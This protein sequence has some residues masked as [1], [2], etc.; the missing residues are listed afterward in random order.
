MSK[1][2]PRAPA[3]PDPMAVAN[4]QTQSNLSTANAE[5]TLNRTNQVTP[6]G[7]LTYSRGEVGPDGTPQWTANIELSPD[8]QKLLANDNEVSKYLSDLSLKQMRQVDNTIGKPLDMSSL[9]WMQTAVD[10]SPLATNVDPNTQA[11]RSNVNAGN[12]RDSIPDS[13]GVM[14]NAGYAGGVTGNVSQRNNLSTGVRASNEYQRNVGDVGD[15]SRGAT[16]NQPLQFGAESGPINNTIKGAGDPLRNNFQAGNM[17]RG[18]DSQYDRLRYD[19]NGKP[20][21]DRLSVPADQ[22]SNAMTESQKAAYNLQSQ[23]LDA[24]YGER[25]RAL[26]NRLI[27]QGVVQGSEAWDRAM[28]G[29]GRQRTFDYNNAFNNSFDKG[30]AANQ[31]LFG[32]D[33]ASGQFVNSAQSQDFQQQ[34]ANAQLSNATQNQ[35]FGQDFS[36]AQLNNAVQGQEFAQNMQMAD[37]FN[38]AQNQQFSQNATNAQFGNQAQAQMYDQRFNNAQLNNAAQN[39][40]FNQSATNAQINNAAQQQLFGQNFNNA[41]LNN[42]VLNDQFG[43]G[44]TNA[45]LNNAAQGQMFGQ[46]VTNAQ[47]QNFAQ[48]QLYNQGMGN[49]QLN[50][51]AQ[52]QMFTQGLAG[53]NTFNNAQNQRF[54]QDFANAQLANQTQGQMFGQGVTNAQLNNSAQNQDFGQRVTNANMTN[55]ARAQML[56]ELLLQQQNPMNM[57]NAL[58]TGSQV[59]APNFTSTPQTNVQGTDTAG[60]TQQGFNN[61]MGFY[62]AD[63]ARNNAIT[64]GLFGL[65]SAFLGGR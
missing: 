4:A 41:Q 6:W 12:V 59:T 45:Q 20:M 7:N 38:R 1:S 25:E 18:V 35:R 16:S 36:N 55:Q 21:Q 40:L 33:L 44:V 24:Q 49:A 60:I 30:L 54:T 56:Q 61:Q 51:A 37:L 10:R 65:G 15:V 31:Q 29:L 19:V 27:Q 62:N 14:R 17:V 42:Q 2:S 26:E 8:Q 52:N 58:R 39:Q 13:G 22:L 11:L 53:V 64:S 47:L 34:L 50:N 28:E 9:P 23:Y 48:N 32:Q 63:M 5:A 3:A 57:L 43:Q 46:D